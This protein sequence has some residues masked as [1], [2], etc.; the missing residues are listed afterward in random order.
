MMTVRFVW[1]RETVQFSLQ[2]ETHPNLPLALYNVLSVALQETSI[3]CLNRKT[4]SP[5]SPKKKSVHF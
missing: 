2:G 1:G 3:T 4:V 5:I